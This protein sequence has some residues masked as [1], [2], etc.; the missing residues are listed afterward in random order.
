MNETT[1]SVPT[2]D[3]FISPSDL[4][5]DLKNPRVPEAH[6]SD[7]EE[8]L[9]HLLDHV[10]IDELIQSILSS[11][12]L[13]YEPLIVR[14]SDNVVLEGNRRLA[15]LRIL[16]NP[17]LREKL[18]VNLPKVPDKAAAPD[19]IRVHF[20][21]SR[22]DARAFIGFKHINGPFKWDALAKAR[23]AADWLNDGE[24]VQQ[25]SRRLGDNHN[26]V[27]R[28]INGWRVLR[29]SYNVG[30]DQ[31]EVSGRFPFSHLYT[32]LPR[33]NVREYLKLAEPSE[34]GVLPKDPVPKK[35]AES[36]RRLMS[37]LYGQKDEPKVVR[38]QNPNLNQLVAV[39]GNEAARSMLEATRDL[40]AAHGE[41]EDKAVRFSIT[42]MS[43]ISKAEETLKLVGNFGGEPELTI[44]ADNLRRTVR[45][46]IDAMKA[47]SMRIQEGDSTDG[48]Q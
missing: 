25:I 17:Q 14:R 47:R 30:F 9:E 37:W 46:L 29:Q 5:L 44:A 32:A 38:S 2:S 45:S 6:F 10:D 13:D 3:A 1:V 34:F 24:D 8:V 22:A 23:Y 39:L 27:V 43:T 26:T 4:R 40:A 19:K 7:E 41:V 31:Q 20:V 15:A 35:K 28:L 12:W 36:L 21:D 48:D 42:L 11:G 16:S 18:R 33:P